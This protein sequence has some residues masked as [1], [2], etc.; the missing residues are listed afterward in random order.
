MAEQWPF[1]DF[2]VAASCPESSSDQWLHS[3]ANGFVFTQ[4]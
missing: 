1:C 3:D 2:G 4:R